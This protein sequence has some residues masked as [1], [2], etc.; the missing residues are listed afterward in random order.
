MDAI[1]ELTPK[2]Q[3]AALKEQFANQESV[4]LDQQKQLEMQG[5][6][7]LDQQ[8]QIENLPTQESAKVELKSQAP[9]KAFVIGKQKYRFNVAAFYWNNEKV[10]SEDALKDESLLKDLVEAGAGVIEAV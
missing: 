9:T 5:E 1:K 6:I 7:L 8:K 2:Q 3:L 10:R 4:I